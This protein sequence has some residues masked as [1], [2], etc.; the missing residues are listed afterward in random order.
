MGLLP[1]LR[2]EHIA[3]LEWEI[4]PQETTSPWSLLKLG[5]QDYSILGKQANKFE[6]LLQKNES[7]SL[8]TEREKRYVW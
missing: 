7:G 2:K 3:G 1:M 8:P 4:V 6:V 5:C